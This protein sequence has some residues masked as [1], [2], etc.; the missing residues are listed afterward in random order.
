M[1][2]RIFDPL[3]MTRTFF[4]GQDVLRDGNYA[5]G[6]NILDATVPPRVL[7]DS[8]D[9]AWAR[10]AGYAWTSLLDLARFVEFLMNGDGAVLP[11]SLRRAMQS[12][13]V[14]THDLLD[15]RQRRH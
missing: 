13:Q 12:P 1:Q 15:R 8:Y 9:N 6:T 5:I 7:P 3:R 14:D 11:S 4:L 2:R 10:P